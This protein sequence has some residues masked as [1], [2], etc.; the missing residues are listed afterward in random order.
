MERRMTER[1]MV[2]AR[3]VEDLQSYKRKRLMCYLKFFKIRILVIF[4]L[5]LYIKSLVVDGYP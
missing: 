2:D 1:G 5:I 4:Y 3:T